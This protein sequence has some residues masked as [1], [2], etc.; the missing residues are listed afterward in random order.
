MTYSYK[1]FYY[2]KHEVCSIMARARCVVI[3]AKN[4]KDAEAKFNSKYPNCV[5]AFVEN[6]RTSL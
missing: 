5:F 1:V 2:E 6:P 4:P 3:R